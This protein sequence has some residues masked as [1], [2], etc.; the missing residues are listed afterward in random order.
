MSLKCTLGDGIVGFSCATECALV[1]TAD[2]EVALAG[3]RDDAMLKS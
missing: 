1:R 2:S 3:Q